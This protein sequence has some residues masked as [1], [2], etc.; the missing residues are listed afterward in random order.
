MGFELMSG[1][2]C[3]VLVWKISS[4]F[5]LDEST[6]TAKMVCLDMLSESGRPGK[7]VT[8]GRELDG[9]WEGKM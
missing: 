7:S 4:Q 6:G 5:S 2:R 1:A 9:D 3:E 8:S